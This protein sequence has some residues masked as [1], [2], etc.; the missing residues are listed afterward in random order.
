MSDARLREFERQLAVGD[1]DGRAYVA[2]LDR[3]RPPM[4]PASPR[5]IGVAEYRDPWPAAVV[6]AR[7]LVTGVRLLV[8][9][10]PKNYEVV[11]GPCP[12]NRESAVTFEAVVRRIGAAIGLPP[13]VLRRVAGDFSGDRAHSHEGARNEGQGTVA[14]PFAWIDPVR[15]VREMESLERFQ[16]DERAWARWGRRP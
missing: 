6:L 13:E 10:R 14:R 12:T 11:I 8:A 5:W 2:A 4:L 1:L 3:V 16:A 9:A 7:E 15:E